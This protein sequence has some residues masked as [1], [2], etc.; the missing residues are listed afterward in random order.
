M[1][2][3]RCYGGTAPTPRTDRLAGEGARF[4]NYNVEAQCTLPQH[5]AGE[6]FAGY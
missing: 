6:E 3:H 4:K 1:G 5:Q 2:R